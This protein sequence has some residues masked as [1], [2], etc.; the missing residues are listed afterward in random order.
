MKSKGKNGGFSEAH[1][2]GPCASSDGGEQRKV[3]PQPIANG[4]AG[5]SVQLE[6]GGKSA[7][8]TGPNNLPDCKRPP[9]RSVMERRSI[10]YE[11]LC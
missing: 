4:L 8:P 1:V 3:D 2:K 7:G 5:L 9:S 10:D 6:I 11:Y